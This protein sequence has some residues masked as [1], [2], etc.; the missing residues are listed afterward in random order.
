MT[1]KEQNQASLNSS[2]AGVSS[3]LKMKTAHGVGCSGLQ[4]L[5]GH[6]LRINYYY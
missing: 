3:T 4:M 2:T 6:H 5:A 1:K